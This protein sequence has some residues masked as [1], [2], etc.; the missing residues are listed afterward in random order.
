[1]ESRL[2]HFES[3]LSNV[4]SDSRS[5]S[6]A[7]DYSVARSEYSVN[8]GENGRHVAA[9]RDSRVNASLD[10]V[11]ASNSNETSI[12]AMGVL[13]FADEQVSGFFGRVFVLSQQ[14]SS[15]LG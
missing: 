12:N 6:P 13:A 5:F 8:L 10:C 15:L 1:M 14:F 9:V 2:S 3:L 11:E 4:R 7:K